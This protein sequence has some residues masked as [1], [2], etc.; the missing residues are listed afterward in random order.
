[1]LTREEVLSMVAG[2]ELD[3]L[4]AEKVFGYE[5]ITYDNSP[6]KPFS[7]DIASAWEVV[8]KL[9]KDQF[10]ITLHTMQANCLVEV[11]FK[12]EILAVNKSATAPEAI[13]KAVLL[14][15]IESLK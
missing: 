8:K 2:R 1:L 7:T 4:V 10:Y 14:L 6:Y 15:K 5:S 3:E 9:E 11:F 12:N 13:C